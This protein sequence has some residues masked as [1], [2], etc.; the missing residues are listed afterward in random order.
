MLRVAGVLEHR[1][2]V[3]ERPPVLQHRNAVVEAGECLCVTSLNNL[4]FSDAAPAMR[5]HVAF[6]IE[7]AGAPQERQKP[8]NL[9][10]MEVAAALAGS[11][12]DD[13]PGYRMNGSNLA[14]GL[15]AAPASTAS[16]GSAPVRAGRNQAGTSL[17][18]LLSGALYICPGTALPTC[19]PANILP[20]VCVRSFITCRDICLREPRRIYVLSRT[21]GCREQKFAR[22]A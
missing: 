9:A 18:Q 15:F 21:E 7:H 8:G 6:Q 1:V 20:S 4:V 22:H 16:G 19:M 5:Q 12:E 14:A 3:Q 2:V 17:R 13:V 10:R 11:C